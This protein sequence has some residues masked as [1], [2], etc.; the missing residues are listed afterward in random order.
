MIVLQ[1]STKG[2]EKMT[3]QINWEYP[4][5]TGW[6]EYPFEIDGVQFVSKLD[7]NGSMY[8]KVINNLSNEQF[9]KMNKGFLMAEFDMSASEYTP[10]E[11]LSK[12]Y[13]LN[14]GATEALIELV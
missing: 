4:D 9:A 3:T 10:A 5:T 11:L 7:T 8:P 14:E 2:N 13:V 12:L 6:A 1:N